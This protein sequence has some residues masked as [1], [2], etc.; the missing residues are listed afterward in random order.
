MQLLSSVSAT[1]AAR[2][3]VTIQAEAFVD[4]QHLVLLVV[5]AA[6]P[7][8][9]RRFLACMP[10]PG[11]LR[12]LPASTAEEAVDRGGCRPARPPVRGGVPVTGTGTQARR[13]R[14]AETTGNDRK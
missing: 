12:V 5:Q 13:V 9:V 1:T 7:Q 3:G 6:T 11:R 2:Y 8:A 4:Q 10:G 14:P